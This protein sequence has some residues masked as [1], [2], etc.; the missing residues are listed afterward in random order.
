MHYQSTEH[1]FQNAL[2][3]VL[4]FVES[5]AVGRSQTPTRAQARSGTLLAAYAHDQEAT[6]Y[7][8]HKQ[9]LLLTLG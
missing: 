5:I 2:T 4:A 1:A 7:S 9:P 3:R 8:D 6:S